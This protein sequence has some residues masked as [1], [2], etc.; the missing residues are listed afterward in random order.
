LVL[1]ASSA[2]ASATITVYHADLTGPAEAP[3]NASP[4]TGTANVTIDDVADTMRVQ[5]SFAGLVGQ[6][7]ASHIHCCTGT[8]GIGTANVATTLPTF[9]NFPLGVT[10]GTFDQT[11]DMTLAGS[12]NPAFVS[13]NG[14][15]EASAFQ[16]LIAGIN[17]GQAYLNIHSSVNPGGEIRGFLAAVPEPETYAFLALGLGLLGVVARRRS[18][19]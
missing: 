14:G 8:P 17:A 16:A 7:T 12:Y 4:G 13:G 2:L 5:V 9:P 11:F 3:P 6:T 1:A 18:N 15:T 19:V 10:S